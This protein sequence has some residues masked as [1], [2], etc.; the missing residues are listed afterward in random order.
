MPRDFC[1]GRIHIF[2]PLFGKEGQPFRVIVEP[3]TGSDLGDSEFFFCDVKEF[4]ETL[5]DIFHIIK[6]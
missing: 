1:I 5:F 3:G 4:V 6:E 2:V